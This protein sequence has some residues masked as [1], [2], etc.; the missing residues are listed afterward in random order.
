MSVSETSGNHTDLTKPDVLY[1]FKSEHA[2]VPKFP[3]I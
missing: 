1:K 2:K 3:D